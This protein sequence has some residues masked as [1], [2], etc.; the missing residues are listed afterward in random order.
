MTQQ[1]HVLLL[2]PDPVGAAAFR[3]IAVDRSAEP[4][5]L[6]TAFTVADA[7]EALS[8]SHYDAVVVDA[9]VDADRSSAAVD[10]VRRA[11]REAAVLILRAHAD[12][13]VP[14]EPAD[15][16]V[17]STLDLASLD[18]R[19]LPLTLR[20]A[21]ERHRLTMA[22]QESQR[23]AR[24]LARAKSLRDP[25]TGLVMGERLLEDADTFLADAVRF[26]RPL[27]VAVAD[28][29]DFARINAAR[30]PAVADAILV[31]IAQVLQQQLRASDMVGR[32][33]GDEFLM[34]MPGTGPDPALIAVR[35]IQERLQRNP[36]T[37]GDGRRIH[38][39]ISVGI[40][41]LRGLMAIDELVLQ[42]DQA[43]EAARRCGRGCCRLADGP[44]SG[45]ILN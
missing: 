16:G 1:M 14:L 22:L 43:M 12:D 40:A 23:Q 24:E 21:I 31:H 2:E 42:A 10:G 3:T 35:R 8:Q 39:S 11:A 19:T 45:V 18:E 27:T 38:A 28:V 41:G 33:G 26:G 37:T 30:G 32:L 7:L 13:A 4:C 34:I 9:A 20:M 17:Q 6:E 15:V 36:C 29:D 44:S 5:L 25:L